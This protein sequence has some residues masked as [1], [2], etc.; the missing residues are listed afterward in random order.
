[1]RSPA[2][3]ARRLDI[4]DQ[5]IGAGN[6]VRNGLMR[7]GIAVGQGRQA[8]I[9]QPARQL[10]FRRCTARSCQRRLRMRKLSKLARIAAEF[11]KHER[12]AR[13]E[14]VRT[15]QRVSRR[16]RI[17]D[18]AQRGASHEPGRPAHREMFDR[19]IGEFG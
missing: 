19:D 9:M 16:Q 17:A 10:P 12:I 5:C 1:M 2:L 3:P 11:A 6:E 18:Q 7:F 13:S 14:F 4:G 8:E 15:A